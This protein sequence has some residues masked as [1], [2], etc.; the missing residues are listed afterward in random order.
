MKIAV[1]GAGGV[2]G[3]F[4][5]RL[6]Q[7]GQ[8]VVFVAR[9]N[10]YAAL[11]ERGLRVES[12]D[13]DFTLSP[14]AVVQDAEEVGPVEA[15]IVATKAWQVAEA[16]AKMHALLGPQTFLVPL[17]NGVESVEK[18]TEAHGRERVLGAVC[19]ISSFLAEPGLIRH[20]GTPASIAFGELDGRRSDRAQLLLEA[21][22]HSPQI[23]ARISEE[24]QVVMWQKFVF[25]SAVSC[26]CSLTR[27][28]IG[29]VRAVP[30][31]RRLLMGAMQ[32][33]AAVGRARGVSLPE[34]LA[35][36][37]MA[38]MDRTDGTVLPSM[39]R[40]V[41]DGKPSELE[42]MS[43]TVARMG[44]ALGIPTPCHDFLYAALLP[45]ERA[46]RLGR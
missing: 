34:D 36:Q 5:G 8:D 37:T 30:E 35:D 45:Q 32:E 6:A 1:V 26:V 15:V 33:T 18:L 40:D 13:G 9:G 38:M 16:A 7:S 3:Y 39:Q 23:R 29:A 19:R 17:E 12:I 27:Q 2:G 14:A 25:I 4:G 20:V 22:A 24:I 31:T 11:R 21:F 41:M 44:R 28:P 42:S 10:Q 43:G 46:A